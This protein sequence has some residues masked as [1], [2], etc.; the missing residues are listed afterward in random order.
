MFLIRA[1]TIAHYDA[2]IDLMT[3][4]SGIRFRD[5][6]SLESTKRYPERN[7]ARHG[8]GQARPVA[9]GQKQKYLESAI[10]SPAVF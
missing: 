6:D 7:P 5:A 9:A 3:H 8:L 4:T 10:L 2:V 1:M